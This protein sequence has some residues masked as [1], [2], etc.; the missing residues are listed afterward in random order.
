MLKEATRSSQSCVCTPEEL[1]DF[2]DKISLETGITI[3]N[4]DDML[5]KPDW[6]LKVWQNEESV[7]KI[8]ELM[9]DG[10]TFVDALNI[11]VYDLKLEG[12][13]YEDLYKR[14]EKAREMMF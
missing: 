12:E 11:F 5:T 9:E 2:C 8:K 13:T 7:E 4:G 14:A 1:K 10:R 3:E 6:T